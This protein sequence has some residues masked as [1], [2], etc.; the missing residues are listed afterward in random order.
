M[1]LKNIKTQHDL[2]KNLGEDI[3]RFL[4]FQLKPEQIENTILKCSK[5][6]S[7]KMHQSGTYK[8]RPSFIISI[9]IDRA[10]I[11]EQVYRKNG[12]L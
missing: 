9:G 10:S 7:D 1:K 4:T 2:A 8:L 5:A 12:M 11:I 6:F 3:D